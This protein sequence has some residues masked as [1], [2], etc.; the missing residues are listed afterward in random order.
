M[1]NELRSRTN[2]VAGAI[3]TALASGDT[4]MASAGLGDLGVIDSTN[5]AAIV[6]FAADSAGRITAKE[7]V[8]VTAHTA[9]A[10]T[11]TIARAKESTSAVAWVVGSTWAHAA[12]ALDVY[13]PWLV[14]I[15]TGIA[16][17]S[18]SVGTWTL[19][20]IND[21]T[22]PYIS[23][24]LNTG[25]QND[26]ISWDIAVSAGLWTIVLDVRKSTNLGIYTVQIDGV[27]AGTLDGYSASV[28]HSR[29]SL[30]GVAMTAGHHTLKIL[31]ATKNA[32]SS[33]YIG[34]LFGISLRRTT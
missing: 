9:S 1:A 20:A 3:S 17:P 2:L 14:N 18:A 22:Y 6:L 26:Y 7:I 28:A 21:A 10:T 33:S 27:S 29:L 8:Y 15:P 11:A 31:M 13:E 30:T 34:E 5:H 12:T 32:S 19:L 23:I 25:T 16:E 4:T 24:L